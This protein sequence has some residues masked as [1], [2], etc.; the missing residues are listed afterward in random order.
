M[1]LLEKVQVRGQLDELISEWTV[2][3]RP[4][5]NFIST[6]WDPASSDKADR[7]VSEFE[8]YSGALCDM[9]RDALAWCGTRLENDMTMTAK[10]G[11]EK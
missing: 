6:Y 1:S 8:T 11:G 3:E 10:L 2:E 9:Y 4:D 5:G 7:L